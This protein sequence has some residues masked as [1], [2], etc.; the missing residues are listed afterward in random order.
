[1]RSSPRRAQSRSLRTHRIGS[2]P[3]QSTRNSCKHAD[4]P[5]QNL[6]KKRS[7]RSQ[8]NRRTRLDRRSR[9]TRP[10]LPSKSTVFPSKHQRRTNTAEPRKE[11]EEDDEGGGGARTV[12]V[13][14]PRVR[15][16]RKTL[17]NVWTRTEEISPGW[18]GV[19]STV[20]SLT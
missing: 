16:S 15:E 2:E 5:H 20:D 17:I 13:R 7:K 18:V 3:P 10:I 19:I 6:G 4:F 14:K 9:S 12:H 8:A 11:E 1:M